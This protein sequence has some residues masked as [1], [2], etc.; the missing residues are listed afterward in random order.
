MSMIDDMQLQARDRRQGAGRWVGFGADT[1]SLQKMVKGMVGSQQGRRVVREASKAALEIFNVETGKN[2]A[3]LNLKPS[4]RGW[5]KLLTKRKAYKYK[6]SATASGHFSAATGIN[7]GYAILRISHLVERGFQH[8]RAGKVG[9]N[10]FRMDAFREK[11]QEV[12][13]RFA[14]NMA[15]GFD[16]MNKT[17][18]APSASQMRKRFNQ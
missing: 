18:K 1:K 10:W 2:A 11:K 16:R 7:Y 14:A 8:F 4:G 3:A 6:A 17:G 5:R 9:G 12:F 15:W 13:N